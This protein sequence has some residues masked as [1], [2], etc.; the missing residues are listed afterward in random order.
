MV[1][2]KGNLELEKSIL[3]TI[4]STITGSKIP[5][6][7]KNALCS[8]D[9]SLN[10]DFPSFPHIAPVRNSISFSKSIIKVVST[11]SIHPGKLVC[12][13]NV[14]PQINPLVLVLFIQV[15]P[16]VTELSV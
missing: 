6:R 9:F 12:D 3:K 5:S 1:V 16:L 11:S 14:L 2:E 15:N 4:D 13:S 7:N 8:T 10:L